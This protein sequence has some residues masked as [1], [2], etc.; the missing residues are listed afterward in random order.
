MHRSPRSVA[1]EFLLGRRWKCWMVTSERTD[2]AFHSNGFNSGK[3]ESYDVLVKIP[4]LQIHSINSII[5]Y[6]DRI[7]LFCSA[8]YY[9]LIT[10]SG[11]KSLPH[12]LYI[13]FFL[14]N[15]NNSPDVLKWLGRPREHVHCYEAGVL[16]PGFWKLQL[17]LSGLISFGGFVNKQEC[18]MTSVTNQSKETI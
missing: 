1:V 18:V 4:P 12:S 7:P 13:P 17:K 10:I 11:H 5:D 6:R 14:R 9:S 16:T 8:Y 2:C 15:W 3:N